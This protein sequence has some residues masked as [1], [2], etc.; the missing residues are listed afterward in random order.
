MTTLLWITVL[1]VAFA[2]GGNDNAKGVA[3]LR[4]SGLSGYTGAIFWRTACTFIG[5]LLSAKFGARLM[6]LFNGGG[7][8][9]AGAAGGHDFLLVVAMATAATVLVASRIGAPISTTHALTG[10]LIGA[11]TAAVGAGQLHLDILGKAIFLPLLLSPLLSLGLTLLIFPLVT[12]LGRLAKSCV[13][14]IRREPVF[15]SESVLMQSRAV[16]PVDLIIGT[17]SECQDLG[18]AARILSAEPSALAVGRSDEFFPR[19]E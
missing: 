12:P 1:L 3:T 11:G 18:V 14:L 19:V 9:P 8:L 13:C 4:G 10:G 6:A 15:V 17:P 5:A 16:Q 7:L 2:N